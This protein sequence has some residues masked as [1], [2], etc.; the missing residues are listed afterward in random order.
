M[1]FVPNPVR[2][3]IRLV[4]Q[5]Y[6]A[7]Q[8]QKSYLI[9]RL[10]SIYAYRASNKRTSDRGGRGKMERNPPVRDP[11]LKRLFGHAEVVET[12]IRD[13]LPEDVGRIDFDTLERW[14]PNSSARRSFAGTPTCCGRPA[15]ATAPAASSS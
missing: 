1:R 6:R 10:T 12:L 9:T 3:G 8:C 11:L 13:M 5:E 7:P 14:A 4:A 15:P 2:I